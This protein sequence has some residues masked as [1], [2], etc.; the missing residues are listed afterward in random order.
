MKT[1]LEWMKLKEQNAGVFDARESIKNAL[2]NLHFDPR[3]LWK[4]LQVAKEKVGN[5][6]TRRIIDQIENYAMRFM[7][8]LRDRAVGVNGQFGNMNDPK[9]PAHEAYKKYSRL[10]YQAWSEFD[11]LASQGQ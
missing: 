8:E 10:M 6:P 2:A 1:F 7:Q 4:T 9:S 5:D 3:T 11:R